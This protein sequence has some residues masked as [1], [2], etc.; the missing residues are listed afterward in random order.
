MLFP[1]KLFSYKQSVISKFPMVLELLCAEPR[2]ILGLYRMLMNNLS[3]VSEYMDVL[4]ALYAL[5][6]IEFDE[7]QGVLIYVG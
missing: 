6:K 5:G 1:D 3:G 2:T 4:D 7:E